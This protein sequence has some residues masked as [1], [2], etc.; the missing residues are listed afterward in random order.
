MIEAVIKHLRSISDKLALRSL[1]R[2]ADLVKKPSYTSG[3]KYGM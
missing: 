2:A 1:L 3:Y